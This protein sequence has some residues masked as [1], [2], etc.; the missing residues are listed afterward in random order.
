MG[1][2]RGPRRKSYE[3]EYADKKRGA[4]VRDIEVGTAWSSSKIRETS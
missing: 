3:K 1:R 4:K 2:K